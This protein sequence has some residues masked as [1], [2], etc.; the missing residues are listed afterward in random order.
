MAVEPGTVPLRAGA[1]RLKYGAPDI[2]NNSGL[3]SLEPLMHSS[4]R[5]V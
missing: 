4:A 3:P 2:D 1:H 5:D